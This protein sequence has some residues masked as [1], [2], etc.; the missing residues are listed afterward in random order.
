MGEIPTVEIL[1]FPVSR[2]SMAETVKHL[3]AEIEAGRQK[4]C[5]HWTQQGA[6]G[7]EGRA[8]PAAGCLEG[9]AKT[10]VSPRP[11]FRVV[12]ANAEILYA[13]SR[14]PEQA[15]LL[16][17]ADLITPDGIGTVKA[18]AAL[19]RPVAERVTG[20]DL[21]VRLCQEGACRGWSAYLLGAAE[22]SVTGTAARLKRDWPGLRLLGWH[23]GYFDAAEK[24]RIVEEISRLKPDLLFIALGFPG[25]ECFGE[26]YRQRLG[27]GLCMGVGGSFDVLSGRVRRAPRW[28]QG[29]GMEWAYRFAQNPRRLG[30][31]WALP[32]FLLAVKGQIRRQNR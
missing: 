21:M 7:T 10:G 8:Q 31:I 3:A 25:Q 9:R 29:I 14:K 20:V 19:G 13:A 26:E 32:K 1:G 28:I 17:S 5:A 15:A 4:G 30:R 22:E 6:A 23:N 27:A 12:T 16:N 18:A 11:L 24:E 2:L